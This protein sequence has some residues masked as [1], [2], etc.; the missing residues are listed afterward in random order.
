MDSQHR[1]NDVSDG[2]AVTWKVQGVRQEAELPSAEEA[3][4]FAQICILLCDVAD[5]RLLP[6]IGPLDISGPPR[7]IASAAA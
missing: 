6:P 2:W 3:R 7:Q 5:V 4:A 1:G